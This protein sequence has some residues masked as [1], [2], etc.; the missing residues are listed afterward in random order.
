MILKV[1]FAGKYISPSSPEEVDE[2]ISEAI[3]FI[4]PGEG[5]DDAVSRNEAW[6]SFSEPQAAF[7]SA[8][9]RVAAN[10]LTGFGA[11]VWFTFGR[12]GG[13]Y[14]D[15]W[16]SDN[17]TPPQIESRLVCDPCYPRFHDP[18]SAVPLPQVREAIKEFCGS[19]TGERP[20]SIIWTTGEINGPRHD[21]PPFEDGQVI[22]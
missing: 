21:R 8:S 11:L 10:E 22:S 20:E 15:A 14:D 13:I 1:L 17:P 9:L 5:G 12:E 2:L 7:P 4:S 6:F 16:I 18:A 3:R 19:A